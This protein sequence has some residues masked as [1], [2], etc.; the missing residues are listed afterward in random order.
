MKALGYVLLFFNLAAAGAFLY[1]AT[2]VVKQ[3]REWTD[4]ALKSE[5]LIHGTA[6]EAGEPI[7]PDDLEENFVAF[8]FKLYGI[9]HITQLPKDLVKKLIPTGGTARPD[10]PFPAKAGEFVTNQTDEVERIRK[11][12][13][14]ELANK[15]N[16][17]GQTR[18]FLSTY[19]INLA[20]TGPE[21]DGINALLRDYPDEAWREY[22]RA[23]LPYVGRTAIQQDAL[24]ALGEL[25][26]LQDDVVRQKFE[27]VQVGRAALDVWADKMLEYVVPK[28]VP[29]AK[30]FRAEAAMTKYAE[31]HKAAEAALKALIGEVDAE[32]PDAA[33]ITQGKARINEL[34][35][36]GKPTKKLRYLA[37][38]AGNPLRTAADLADARKQLLDLAQYKARTDA[39]KEALANVADLLMPPPFDAK[40]APD[41]INAK[42]QERINQTPIQIAKLLMKANFDEA[43][44]PAAQTRPASFA[45]DTAQDPLGLL[46]DPGEKQTSVAHLLYNL[47]ANL[48]A[49]PGDRKAWHER[50]VAIIGMI[51]YVHEAE[52][53]AA[54][55]E[56][57]A[58][59][60]RTL[61][62][63][64]Q[65][66]F[67][68]QYQE[69]IEYA[70]Y[71]AFRLEDVQQ[72]LKEQVELRE[73]HD[74][75]VKART[76]ERDNLVNELNDE[77]TKTKAALDALQKRQEELFSI[78]K[79]LGEAQDALVGL[80]EKL[81]ELELSFVKP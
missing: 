49:K 1:L 7:P 63:D 40:L 28:P 54:A 81:R 51:N 42:K 45:E 26:F 68:E 50:V 79:K 70:L 3:K 57:I 59:R 77:R 31:D 4:A 66:A 47:D 78:T 33:K 56:R 13:D 76:S 14:A 21:R 29:D 27:N 46:R 12:F 61:V 39:E 25:A 19:L 38:I 80:E 37:D 22:G 30:G 74:T 52:A 58:P 2:M 69:L 6:I 43:A 36:A 73:Q 18:G 60:V 62:G 35:L 20:R 71:L 72:Q 11:I 24:R 75:L 48:Y 23:N 17:P 65:L 16:N 44:L 64:E 53:Q 34:D 67:E 15:A 41:E 5:V 9:Q 10:F 32:N 55:L 8:G